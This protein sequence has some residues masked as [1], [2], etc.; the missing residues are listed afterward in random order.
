MAMAD[1]F[2]WLVHP[3][4]GIPWQCPIGAV[5]A[6]TALGHEPSDPLTEADPTKS[7]GPVEVVD[8]P[9]PDAKAPAKSSRKRAA[10]PAADTEEGAE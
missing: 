10:E 1:E 4:V 9:E 3:D 5:G 6:W 8:E 2:V 7:D